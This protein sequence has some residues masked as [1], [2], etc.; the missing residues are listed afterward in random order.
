MNILLLAY[1]DL[2]KK[3]SEYVIMSVCPSSYRWPELWD[4]MM[5]TSIEVYT[6]TRHMFWWQSYGV[7]NIS[8]KFSIFSVNCFPIKSKLC[9]IVMD[10]G[11]VTQ[12]AFLDLRGCVS[13]SQRW[14]F[15]WHISRLNKNW[16]SVFFQIP[17]SCIFYML[18]LVPK[19]TECYR[20]VNL[21]LIILYVASCP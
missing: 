3:R 8:L 16:N 15:I 13:I 14:I 20:D 6:F 19:S 7:E 21:I 5:I 4:C 10:I 18:H 11:K 1:V 12:Y 2:H 9:M 17:L